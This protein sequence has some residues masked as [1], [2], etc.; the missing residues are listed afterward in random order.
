MGKRYLDCTASEIRRMNGKEL[1]DAIAGS[2]G[3]LLV[4]ETIGAVRPM[5]GDVTNAEFA[6]AMGADLIIL[7]LFGRLC[8]CD[9]GTS[10]YGAGHRSGDHDGIHP[11]T[12]VLRARAGETD[13]HGHRHLPGRG[14]YRHDPRDRAHVQDD[15]D[16]SASSG[17]LRLC[18]DGT[19]GKYSGIWKS[20][21]GSPPYLSQDGLLYKPI[22]RPKQKG[23]VFKTV[24]FSVGDHAAPRRPLPHAC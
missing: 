17:R 24:P 11:Q 5:L 3:R 20:D 21:T 19:A 13:A 2:E 23:A 12:G 15:R 22:K 4:C 18:G 10:G 6:A 7:N 1:A 8:S 9:P 14:R 16:G